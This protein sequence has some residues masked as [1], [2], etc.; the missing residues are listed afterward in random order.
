MTKT[1][2]SFRSLTVFLPLRPNEVAGPKNLVRQAIK[3]TGYPVLWLRA[4]GS[5]TLYF[6]DGG[7]RRQ[8]T[9]KKFHLEVRP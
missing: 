9:W 1:N 2:E 4:N 7:E 6:L 8:V 3:A 5:A